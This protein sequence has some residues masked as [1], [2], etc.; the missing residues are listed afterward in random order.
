LEAYKRAI[1]ADPSRVD[2]YEDLISLLLYLHKT[3]DAIALVNHALE[4]APNDARPWVWKGNVNVH[5]NAYKDAM[6]SYSRAAKLDSS[7]AD[8]ML[9]MAVVYFVTGQSDAAIAEYKAGIA[10]FPS[11][12]RFYV[13]CAEMLLG[14]PD[15]LKLQ[16]Q[17]ETLLQ[18]AVRLAPQSAEAHYQLGQ[19]AMQQTRLKD[20]EA[21]FLLSL[22]SDPDRSKAHFALS[23]VYRRMGRA[24]DAT[25]EFGIYQ[26][27][28]HAE[29]GGTTAAMPM[30]GER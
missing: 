21:E 5:S 8:A 22:Q 25:R 12:A 16:T 28:K 20:A 11:D 23:S 2:Y 3:N 6:A 1:K 7:N 18:K 27:L 24:T 13:A 15:S 29:E 26:D 9:G 4:I 10:R 17:A 30:A 14:S 19:L